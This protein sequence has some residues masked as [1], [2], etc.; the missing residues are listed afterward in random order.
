M[1]KEPHAAIA[2]RSY[3]AFFTRK[4]LRW[5]YL[6]RATIAPVSFAMPRETYRD[7]FR[8]LSLMN[9]TR[10]C[11]D[12]GRYA[13]A[14]SFASASLTIVNGSFSIT[15]VATMVFTSTNNASVHV[16]PFIVA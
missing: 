13:A 7:L 2:L 11:A 14:F 6:A 8:T 3:A 15:W 5:E 9:R 4:R 12:V 16:T 10:V 1:R